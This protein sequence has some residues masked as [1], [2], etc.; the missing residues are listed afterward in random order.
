M[1]S[2][3][4]LFNQEKKENI[5][6]F[7]KRICVKPPKYNDITRQDIYRNLIKL[8]IDD[9]E[10]ILRL[11]NMEEINI[12]KNLLEQPLPK[13]NNGYIEYLLLNELLS[14]Y[15]I[16][17]DHECYYIPDDLINPI[18]M[19]MNLFNEEEY[20]L[21]DVTDSVLLGLLRTHNVL[22]LDEIIK[23]LQEYNIIFTIPS[24]KEY[25]KNSLRNNNK[26]AL[27]KDYL[28]SLEYNYYKDVIS[29]K[30]DIAP[31]HGRL[32]EIISI[33]KYKINLFK[34]PIFNF[35]C[36]LESH[37]NPKYIDL[38]IDDLIVYAGFDL[39]E[40]ETLK[41]IANNIPELYTKLQAI[42]GYFPVWIFNGCAKN[43]IDKST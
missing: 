17:E 32:E 27:K 43:Q 4:E 3:K 30:K 34:E 18:K 37:L 1:I 10:I 9:P 6:T 15:L 35:L 28:I 31:I 39:D 16:L 14:N 33:G 22:T 36:Y 5:Y 41:A 20:G 26:I 11:C 8:Y 29:L 13:K 21:K 2:L 19:A 23:Y 24:L 38:I 25:L 7:Y 12:L 42:I 40:E